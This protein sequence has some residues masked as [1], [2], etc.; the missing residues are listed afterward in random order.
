M[1]VEDT[2]YA[3]V[4]IWVGRLPDPIHITFATVS[5]QVFQKLIFRH[6]LIREHPVWNISVGGSS[7]I[8]LD[9]SHN[10]CPGLRL[11][12]YV[13]MLDTFIKYCN[14][15][16]LCKQLP[17]TVHHRSVNAEYSSLLLVCGA[18]HSGI[19]K[20]S[21]FSICFLV[22]SPPIRIIYLKL[23][24]CWPPILEKLEIV[25]EV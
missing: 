17:S 9:L 22:C 16:L 21:M 10:S 19:K 8:P 25:E 2:R 11:Y 14:A 13:R 15:F 4:V 18:E 3:A 1:L 5:I 20:C 12:M 7:L 6:S 24:K 23:P